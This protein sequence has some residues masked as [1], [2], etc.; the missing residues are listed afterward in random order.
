VTFG[1]FI[2]RD[3]DEAGPR[4]VRRKLEVCIGNGCAEVSAANPL[5]I[6]FAERIQEQ[7]A[8][9]RQ[10]GQSSDEPTRLAA[11]FQ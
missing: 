2:E 6:E 1:D 9:S 7:A 3:R 8:M 5:E 11:V 10:F 4:P